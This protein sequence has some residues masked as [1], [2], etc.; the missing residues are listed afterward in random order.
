MAVLVAGLCPGYAAGADMDLRGLGVGLY[1]DRQDTEITNEQGGLELRADRVGIRLAERVNRYLRLGLEGG[2]VAAEMTGR[3]VAG[4]LQPS[5]NFLGVTADGAVFGGPGG[6]LDY[7]LDLS[8]QST[9]DESGGERVELDWWASEVSLSLR[10]VV[11]SMVSLYAGSRLGDLDL[12]RR[13]RG[14]AASTSTFEALDRTTAFAGLTV[15][16]D[17]GGFIGLTVWHGGGD[18]FTLAFSREY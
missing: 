8:Y 12:D 15:E 1:V 3:G 14:A 5:G 17:P 11:S 6:G 16:V 9:E 7:R 4:A 2:I 18:G 10:W 13:V